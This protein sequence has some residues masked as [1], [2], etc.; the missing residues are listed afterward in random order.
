MKAR[1]A[2]V[3]LDRDGTLNEDPGF[4]S[5]PSLVRLFDGVPA[6]LKLLRGL[7]FSLVVVSN[8]SGIGRG[9][10]TA[11]VLETV[12]RRIFELA[13]DTP[14][15]FFFCPHH[16]EEAQGTYRRSCRCRKPGTGMVAR[17]IRELKLDAD[18]SYMVGD[19]GADVA[20]GQAA[21]LTT[22]LVQT[23]RG[24]ET[25]ELIRSGQLAPPHHVARD[26]AGA[27]EWIA[28]QLERIR[29]G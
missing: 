2:A 1:G 15:R 28:S 17:G 22:V 27:A 14:D 25:L 3:F 16:P 7:G 9:Y 24:L 20:C 23:G 6:A 26:L 4:L 29:R 19:S 21:G 18:S 5:D 10:F 11:E 13:G 12:N 8:Q